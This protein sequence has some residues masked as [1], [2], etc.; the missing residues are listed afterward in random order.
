[1]PVE[2]SGRTCVYAERTHV[3]DLEVELPSTL[4]VPEGTLGILGIEWKP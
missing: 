2:Y 1:M 3:R 4:G